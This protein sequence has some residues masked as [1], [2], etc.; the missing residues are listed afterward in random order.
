VSDT[1]Q[2]AFATRR[3][4]EDDSLEPAYVVHDP[5]EIERPPGDEG[6]R[7]SG[8]ELHAPDET[9]EERSDPDAVLAPDLAW[10]IARYPAFGELVF[11]G[12]RDGWW[13]R[14]PGTGRYVS[15]AQTTS[16]TDS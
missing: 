1:S 16:A 12:A 10:L 2:R 8:W 7:S 5:S 11:S 15:D 3:L 6:T 14:D 4:I 13:R 9:D